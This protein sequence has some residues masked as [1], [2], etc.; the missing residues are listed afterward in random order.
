M[1]K[2]KSLSQFLKKIRLENGD[3]TM[4]TMASNIGISVSYLSS[5]ESEKR[6]MTDDLYHKI[7]S[8]YKLNT[9]EQKELLFFKN[10]ASKKINVEIDT[11]SP[12]SRNL[13]VNFLSNV[14]S[15]SS[16]DLEKINKIIN[17][18]GK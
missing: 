16:D 9:N 7:C 14:D 13:T 15:L 2:I 5:V 4:T 12:D 17:K 1:S 8:L 6:P 3:E 11:L 10:L 18:K